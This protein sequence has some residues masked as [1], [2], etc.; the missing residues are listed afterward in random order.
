MSTK[1]IYQA[2]LE[3]GI[4]LLK[5]AAVFVETCGPEHRLVVEVLKGSAPDVKS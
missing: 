5:D 2:M 1:S 4:Y 3:A